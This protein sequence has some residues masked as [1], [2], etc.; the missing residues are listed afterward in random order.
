MNTE[1]DYISNL[2]EKYADTVLRV[3]YTYLNNKADAEDVVQDVFLKVM[4]K[5]PEFN[6]STHE[7]A[8]LLRTAI[9]MCKNKT[10]LFWNKNKCSIDEIAEFSAFDSYSTD[11]SVLKAVMS[12]PEKYRIPVYMFYYEGYSTAETAKILGKNEA[13]IRSNLSRAR[14]KL[15]TIL[16]EEY[17]FE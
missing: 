3:S 10:N 15:K 14:E 9:N 6:D 16:K 11:N 1:T 5:R 2:V 13:T 8:W 4:E 7:K 12:L 17:D